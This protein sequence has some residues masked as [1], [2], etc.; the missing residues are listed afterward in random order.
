MDSLVYTSTQYVTASSRSED[1]L[2]Q[3]QY[4]MDSSS[5][6]GPREGSLK[7]CKTS[8]DLDMASLAPSST[9][10]PGYGDEPCGLEAYSPP[11]LTAKALM[12]H[13]KACAVAFSFGNQDTLLARFQ[14]D[15]NYEGTYDP[16]ARQKEKGCRF[17]WFLDRRR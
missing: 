16:F 4:L 6:G 1:L 15:Q 8:V 13:E 10:L 12:A 11:R 7:R 9:D 2:R 5:S 17:W 14:Q 3:S